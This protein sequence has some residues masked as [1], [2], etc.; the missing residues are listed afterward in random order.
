MNKRERVTAAFRG[1]ET[2]HVPVCM[3]KHVP[4]A[5][6]AALTIGPARCC[7]P[8]KRKRLKKKLPR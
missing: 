5:F 6:W 1:Q 7:I 3:W 8:R 4:Q 2:D